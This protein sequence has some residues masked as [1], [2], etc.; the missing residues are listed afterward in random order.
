MEMPAFHYS[1]YQ[2]D[3]VLA[4]N[5]ERVGIATYSSFLAPDGAWVSL[6]VVDEAQAAV[7]NE[8]TLLWGEP[9]G[10]SNRP[11]VERHVQMPV[12]ATVSG[13]PFSALARKGYRPT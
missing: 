8:L 3:S 2:Y 10:G 5:G 7:G 13:W 12:G 11:N 6:A 9:G 4:G 1:S